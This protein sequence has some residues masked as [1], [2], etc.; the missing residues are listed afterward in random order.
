MSDS[1][2]VVIGGHEFAGVHTLQALRGLARVRALVP[3]GWGPGGDLGEVE[4]MAAPL[5]DPETLAAGL[6]GAEVAYVCAET[7][8]DERLPPIL[9]PPRLL[10]RA[11]EA[12]RAAGLR[13]LVHVSTADV[14]GSD[15]RGRLTE[16]RPAR[17]EN[18]YERMKLREEEYL[19][20]QVD[21]VDWV[22]VRP[23]RGIGPH[24]RLWSE[25]LIG[26]LAPDRRVW[27]VAGGRVY[28]T[29]IA[30]ADLGRAL[31]AAGRRGQPHH[32]YLVGGF[33]STWRDLLDTAA[34][35]LG[36]QA[37]VQPVPFD[38]AFMHALGRELAT[39]FGRA[40][41]PNAYAVDAFGK[42]HLY[43]D[44]RSRRQLTWSPQ[45]GSFA[46]AIPDVVRWFRANAASPLGGEVAPRRGAGGA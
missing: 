7:P 43:D 45:V 5:D 42:P 33:D 30:G 40:C 38:L 8:P 24:D 3:P 31:V 32:T 12:A 39:G 36:F 4:I 2:H 16:V 18:H 10:V 9:P 26:K 23:A 11:V 22:I 35:E 19:R 27:Q 37:Q 41:W 46:E 25:H 20:A 28:Q 21:D 14:L 29:F 6:A 44:S 15:Q 13:R 1:L 17:P 34:M